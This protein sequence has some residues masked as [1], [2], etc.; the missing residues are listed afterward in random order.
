MLILLQFKT[1][2]VGHFIS[3]LQKCFQLTLLL[4]HPLAILG[5]TGM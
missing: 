5:K 1:A 2:F 3:E 4:T